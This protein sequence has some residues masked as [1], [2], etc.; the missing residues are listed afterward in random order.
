MKFLT[1]EDLEKAS[2]PLKKKGVHI[3]S[4][5]IGNNFDIINLI[6]IA[7]D[8]SSL[9]H[10]WSENAWGNIAEAVIEQHCQAKVGLE[11]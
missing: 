8:D 2:A 4:I 6:T 10:P 5:A 3:Y 11:E 7:H 9:F 1:I